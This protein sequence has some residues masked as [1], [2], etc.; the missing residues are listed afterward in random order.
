MPASAWNAP[1]AVG[2]SNPHSHCNVEDSYYS[3]PRWRCWRTEVKQLTQGYTARDGRTRVQI[4]A[5]RLHNLCS[6]SQC[7]GFLTFMG[8]LGQMMLVVGLWDARQH[9]WPLLTRSQYHFLAPRLWQSKMPPDIA[10]CHWGVGVGQNHP[11]LRTVGLCYA[12]LKMTT[13]SYSMA[14]HN[15]TKYVPGDLFPKWTN[16]QTQTTLTAHLLCPI[17]RPFKNALMPR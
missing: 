9:P 14:T 3:F 12:I 7:Q 11:Q 8:I 2:P 1:P 16:I 13:Y 4:K 10:E 5:V 6:S 15:L 17:Y